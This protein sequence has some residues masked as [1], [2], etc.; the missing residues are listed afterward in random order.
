MTR[1][2]KLNMEAKLEDDKDGEYRRKV[3]GELAQQTAE[4][5][6]TLNRGVVPSEYKQFNLLLQSI[7]A[8]ADT[9]DRVWQHIHGVR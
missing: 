3:L 6:R 4:I 1:E 8:A 7:E 2:A 5:K 9:I